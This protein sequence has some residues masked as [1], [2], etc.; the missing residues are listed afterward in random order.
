MQFWHTIKRQLYIQHFTAVDPVTVFSKF[1]T[2]IVY[3][4]NAIPEE[5]YGSV[6]TLYLDL[7]YPTV[8]YDGES[9]ENLK[10]FKVF[11]LTLPLMY[12]DF[13]CTVRFDSVS[14]PCPGECPCEISNC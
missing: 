13:K 7:I 8:K 14:V 2:I 9:N 11:H 10:I 6:F 5:D 12:E 3:V 4:G 1:M